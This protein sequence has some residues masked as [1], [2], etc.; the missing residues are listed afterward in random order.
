LIPSVAA[1]A[2]LTFLRGNPLPIDL[3]GAVGW[4]SG[5]T[6]SNLILPDPNSI[7]DAALRGLWN[8]QGYPAITGDRIL[9]RLGELVPQ[10]SGAGW[11]VPLVFLGLWVL[12]AFLLV[13]LRARSSRLLHWF[14]STVG[15]WLMIGLALFLG[16]QL[17][18]L[19]S[20]ML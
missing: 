3:S 6:G 9:A 7:Y 16:S 13:F 20:G 18:Q 15:L 19:I 12:M 17:Y 8:S 2:F 4:V 5:V 11:L 1:T 10:L 14:L